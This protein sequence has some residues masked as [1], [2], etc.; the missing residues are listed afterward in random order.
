MFHFDS[1]H[2]STQHATTKS[3]KKEYEIMTF[4]QIMIEITGGAEPLCSIKEIGRVMHKEPA[5]VYGYR[6]GNQPPWDAVVSLS[7][8]LIREHNYYNLAIQMFLLAPY[9][10]ANP[11]QIIFELFEAGIELKKAAKDKNETAYKNALGQITAS[12]ETLKKAV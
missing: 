6:N 8:H 2:E 12:I 1:V 11:E 9:A 7:E 5:T 3:H 4:S 10:N